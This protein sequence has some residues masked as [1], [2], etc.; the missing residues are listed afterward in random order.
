M[1]KIIFEVNG[2]VIESRSGNPLAN[3]K[4]EAWD[5]DVKYNDLLGQTF[6]DDDGRFNLS[7]DSTY[8]REYAPEARP[9][10]LFK[11]FLGKRLLKSSGDKVIYNAGLRTDVT[12]KIEMPEMR[13]E[14]NDRITVEKALKVADFL[15][16]SDFTGLYGQFRKKAS[17]SFGFLSD[18]LLNTVTKLDLTPYKVSDNKIENII[19]QDVATASAHLEN[20]NIAIN[21]VKPYEPKF[22][23]RSLSDFTKLPVILKAGHKVDLYE[24][25]GKVRYYSLVEET[26]NV[27]GNAAEQEAEVNKLKEELKITRQEAANKDEKIN[28]LQMEMELLQK[29]HSEIK[30]LLNSDAVAKLIQTLNKK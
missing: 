16:Q 4:V 12:I 28:K 22:N 17:I 30:T 24:E 8:F 29:D 25:N 7:F 19:G 23:A 11:V 27:S 2:Q 26:K 15:Q 3:L 20:Q 13:P 1:K 9:D 21:E 6:T 14:G 10:L 18:M 5:K